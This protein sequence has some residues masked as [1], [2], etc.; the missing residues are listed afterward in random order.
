MSQNYTAG[1]QIAAG[2]PGGRLGSRRLICSR[3]ILVDTVLKKSDDQSQ[4]CAG[5]KAGQALKDHLRDRIR[6]S[7]MP[8]ANVVIELR[9]A[10]RPKPADRLLLPQLQAAR[11]LRMKTY[12]LFTAGARQ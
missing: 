6:N 10:V 8:C 3:F 1:Y 9:A 4:N 2:S 12:R 7:A 5:R 11:L